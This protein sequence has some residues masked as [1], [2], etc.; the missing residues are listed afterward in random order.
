V[1][2]RFQVDPA[3]LLQGQVVFPETLL[4]VGLRVLL[5]PQRVGIEYAVHA[6]QHRA[7]LQD[8]SGVLAA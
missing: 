2:V 1:A 8:A 6:E 4:A 7:A 5:P 3:D